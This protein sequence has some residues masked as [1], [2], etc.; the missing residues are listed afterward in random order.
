MGETAQQTP[1]APKGGISKLNRDELDAYARKLGIDSPEE[2]DNADLVKDAIKRA[3]AVLEEAAAEPH[4][5]RQEVLDNARAITGYSRHLVAG[6]L[7]GN[8]QEAF[9]KEEATDI[10]KAF[11]GRKQEVK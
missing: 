10:C 7:Q 11:A 2:L 4:Y 9:S 8:D 6:A 5:P 1:E 3:E